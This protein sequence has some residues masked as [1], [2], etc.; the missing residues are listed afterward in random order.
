MKILLLFFIAPSFLSGNAQNTDSMRIKIENVIKSKHAYEASL[1][2]SNAKISMDSFS[3][4][5]YVK[6]GAGNVNTTFSAYVKE[7]LLIKAN[8]KQCAAYLENVIISKIH[9]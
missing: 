5:V 6:A 8:K 9:C 3:R 4:A 1:K 2:L 7:I